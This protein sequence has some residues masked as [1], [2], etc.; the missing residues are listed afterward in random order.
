MAL[1]IGLS[2]SVILINKYI[3]DPALG[4]FPFPLA[5]SATH[6][7]TCSVLSS[8]LVHAGLVESAPMQLSAYVRCAARRRPPCCR[9]KLRSRLT[10]TE[11]ACRLKKLRKKRI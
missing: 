5:L 11:S 7:A 3:L 10:T 4:G 6:M 1:W 8:A 9:G 2:G